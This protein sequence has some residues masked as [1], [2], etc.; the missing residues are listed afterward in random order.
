MEHY[1]NRKHSLPTLPNW[2]RTTKTVP[3][4]LHSTPQHTTRKH[5]HRNTFVKMMPRLGTAALLWLSTRCSSAE[6]TAEPLGAVSSSKLQIHV[7]VAYLPSVV[8]V[9]LYWYS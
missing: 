2:P 4:D 8:F 7:S 6:E 3:L 1:F 5:R 9:L